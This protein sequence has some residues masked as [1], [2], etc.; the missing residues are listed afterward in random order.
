MTDE[1]SDCS[2]RPWRRRILD[3]I[4]THAHPKTDRMNTNQWR[5]LQHASPVPSHDHDWQQ[6]EV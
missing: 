4:S 1:K 2:Y 5:Q 3:R 6:I